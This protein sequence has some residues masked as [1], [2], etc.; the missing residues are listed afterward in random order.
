MARRVVN[1]EQLVRAARA[2]FLRDADVDMAEL[3]A[4][5]AVSRATLYRVAHNRDSVLSDVLWHLADQVLCRARSHRTS[6]GVEG[7]L[8][9]TRYFT[10]Q[11]RAAGAFRAFLR[12]EPETAARVL[13]SGSLHRRAVHAQRQ[14]LLEVPGSC[15]VHLLDQVAFLYVRI[16]ESAL[17]SELLGGTPLDRR[18]AEG[19]ARTILLQAS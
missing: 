12:R 14:I 4:A 7:V 19:A 16:V 6:G 8:E 1:Q 5:L 18:V 3:A 9:V 13:L 2:L 11:L 15:A 17:Y 10:D